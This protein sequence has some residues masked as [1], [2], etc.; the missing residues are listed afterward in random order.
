MSKT[1][2]QVL[3][4][5]VEVGISFIPGIG[6]AAATA[7]RIAGATTVLGGAVS[8]F[9]GT[10]HTRPDTTE[11]AIKSPIPPRVSAYGM[12]RLYG[13]YILFD[14]DAQ[15]AAEDVYAIHEGQMDGPDTFYL[16]DQEVGSSAG[17]ITGAP[18]GSLAGGHVQIDYR[19]GLSTE[20]PYT[21]ITSR[22]PQAW[23]N[24]YRGDGVVTAAVIWG[25]VKTADYQKV[26]PNGQPP[27]SLAARWQRVFDWRDSSQSVTD[28]STWKWSENA[29]LHLVHYLL[30]R[31]N[32][33]WA[34]HFQPTLDYWTAA[35]N[36]C[37][38]PMPLRTVQS[39]VVG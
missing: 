15:S 16:G 17:T 14:T 12:S 2:V 37:D 39:V 30:V 36:D 32:K 6:T 35:A 9:A 26:Y 7:L 23:S 38:V 1:L 21:Q 27:L 19:S 8:A 25:P 3:V 24:S 34:T 4:G 5:A 10:S 11:T 13:A 28:P 33:D 31:D 22:L 29:C 18:D 20:T